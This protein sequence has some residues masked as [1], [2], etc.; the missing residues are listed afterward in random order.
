MS[1]QQRE[2]NH[3]QIVYVFLRLSLTSHIHS[4]C[5]LTRTY[6]KIYCVLINFTVPFWFN[7]PDRILLKTNF[8][9]IRPTKST[10]RWGWGHAF[11]PSA[12]G[13]VTM[14]D[15]LYPARFT[16]PCTG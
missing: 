11:S 2:I 8:A 15:V 10:D 16:L 4:Q 5:D 12:T 7:S 1:D 13:N 3:P 14:E 9:S 6:P